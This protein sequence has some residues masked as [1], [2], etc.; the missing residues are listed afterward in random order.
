MKQLWQQEAGLCKIPCLI[1][2][3]ERLLMTS[4]EAGTKSNDQKNS[5]R[6]IYFPEGLPAFENY[7]DF[8]LIWNEDEAPFIWLQCKSKPRLAFVTI[9]PFLVCSNYLPDITDEDVDLLK[10]E[11]EKD[12]FIISIVNIR[13]QP[14]FSMTANL[15]SPIVINWKEKLGKQVI[16]RN[17]HLYS[18][19]YVIENPAQ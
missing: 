5:I 3:R 19:K 16:L 6:E 12:V 15:L 7:R 17:H 11:E 1:T 8:M 4:T 10:I 18:V 14:E 2:F 9:D 13:N